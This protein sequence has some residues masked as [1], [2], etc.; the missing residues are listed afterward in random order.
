MGGSQFGVT[1]AMQNDA[2]EV[3]KARKKKQRQYLGYFLAESEEAI[4]L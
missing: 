1:F 3:A 2:I 4:Y